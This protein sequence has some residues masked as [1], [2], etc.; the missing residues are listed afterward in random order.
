MNRNLASTYIKENQRLRLWSFHLCFA[1]YWYVWIYYNSGSNLS[2][3][4]FVSQFFNYSTF[5][6]IF[7]PFNENPSFL[8]FMT[9]FLLQT[10]LINSYFTVGMLFSIT[11]RPLIVCNISSTNYL[12]KVVPLRCFLSRWLLSLRDCFQY[13]GMLSLIRSIF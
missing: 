5:M 12:L 8:K 6:V 13:S 7:F 4:F 11:E 3:P 10:G 9:V 1:S 2:F